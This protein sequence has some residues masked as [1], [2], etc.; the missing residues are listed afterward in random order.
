M[1][2]FVICGDAPAVHRFSRAPYIRAHTPAH[3]KLRVF[4]RLDGLR[5]PAAIGGRPRARRKRVICLGGDGQPPNE[6]SRN[7]KPSPT[8]GWPI[9]IF[10]LNNRRLPPRPA[11]P[12][13][14]LRPPRR[15]H[16]LE[17]GVSFP[18]FTKVAAAYGL[19]SSRI[20]QPEFHPETPGAVSPPQARKSARSSSTARRF[21]SP[22]SPPRLPD[23]RMVSR[24]LKTWLPLLDR[25]EL[26]ANMLVPLVE[27]VGVDSAGFEAVI[28]TLTHLGGFP[29]R[30][31]SVGAPR[32]GT[33][34][35]GAP[36][37]LHAQPHGRRIAVMFARAYG[38]ISLPNAL[39]E[40]VKAFR[41]HY[42]KEAASSPSRIPGVVETLNSLHARALCL[43]VLTNKPL[44]ATTS[45]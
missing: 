9:K 26:R 39:A 27:G 43:F 29:P 3:L 12:S 32:R 44:F 33:L 37:P 22:S 5:P 17:S 40:L 8:T 31:R 7:S 34:P 41:Q 36:A 2:R 4:L 18:D 45:I 15:R 6:T 24:R 16:T 21:S 10:V 19:P 25:E 23:G 13:K 35:P 14:L 20:D 1:A 38:P 30:H 42:D 28:L 11:K